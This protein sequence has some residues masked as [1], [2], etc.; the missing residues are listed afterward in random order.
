M[1][2]FAGAVEF[3][4]RALRVG[5]SPQDVATIHSNISEVKLR[6]GLHYGAMEHARMALEGGADRA[7]ALF[8]SV[9]SPITLLYTWLNFY[10]G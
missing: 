10:L 6:L 5:S 3:Y 2:E 8:R 1:S 7:K 4:N 9:S